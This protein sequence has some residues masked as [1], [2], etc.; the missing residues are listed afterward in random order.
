MERFKVVP[1]AIGA[2]ARTIVLIPVEVAQNSD[3]FGATQTFRAPAT[4]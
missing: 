4:A 1:P 2:V 3:G